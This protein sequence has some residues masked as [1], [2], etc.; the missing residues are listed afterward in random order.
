MDLG[1]TLATIAFFLFFGGLLYSIL[2]YNKSLDRTYWEVFFGVAFTGIGEMAATAAVLI[3]YNL[4][5][6]LWWII[7]FPML[8]FGLTGST[9]ML[10]QEIKHRKQKH[11]ADEAER[12]HNGE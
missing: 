7:P 8:A 11:K 2:I 3:K 12:K 4:L 5:K 9:M 6:Q 10:L 1:I